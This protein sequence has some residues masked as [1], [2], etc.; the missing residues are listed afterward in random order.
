MRL[1]KAAAISAK[2]LNISLVITVHGSQESVVHFARTFYIYD[3]MFGGL[4]I[5]LDTIRPIHRFSHCRDKT[6]LSVKKAFFLSVNDMAGVK[7]L[8]LHPQYSPR[9]SNLIRNFP[10]F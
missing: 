7:I 5:P 6:L 2:M 9:M 3:H 1:R 10:Q 8:Q 4:Y